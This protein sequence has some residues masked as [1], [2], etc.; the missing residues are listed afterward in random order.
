MYAEGVESATFMCCITGIWFLTRF[1]VNSL[2]DK[3]PICAAVSTQGDDQSGF[4][5]WV[6]AQQS[7]TL[8]GSKYQIFLG[9][10]II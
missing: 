5:L 7:F 2:R 4:L 1:T 3:H 8:H 6:S 10:K 9:F